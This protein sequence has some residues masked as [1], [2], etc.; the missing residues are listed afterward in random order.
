M[1]DSEARDIVNKFEELFSEAAPPPVARSP[2]P[3]RD[4][5]AI[6]FPDDDP[7]AMRAA[8]AQP[9]A[10]SERR[11]PVF[12]PAERHLEGSKL[13]APRLRPFEMPRGAAPTGTGGDLP[14]SGQQLSPAFPSSVAGRRKS[15]AIFTSIAAALVIG[16]GAGYIA[17]TRTD[18]EAGAANAGSSPEIGQM[19]RFDYELT[20]PSKSAKKRN[21]IR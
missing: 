14:M 3:T 6:E 9:Q 12:A 4:E 13:D 10:R 20:P 21:P 16:I 11:E 7:P 17:G 5:F 2:Q 8:A 1:L 15:K 19:L 18:T